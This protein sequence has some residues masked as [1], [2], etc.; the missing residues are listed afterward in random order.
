MAYRRAHRVCRD[1][2]RGTCTPAACGNF[3][4]SSLSSLT[5]GPIHYYSATAPV[6]A[7]PVPRHC[8]PSVSAGQAGPAKL[9]FSGVLTKSICTNIPRLRAITTI[10]ARA[11]AASVRREKHHARYHVEQT[12]L[13]GHSPEGVLDRLRACKSS[14]AGSLTA[15]AWPR[16]PLLA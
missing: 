12:R 4:S 9:T 13:H 15:A 2:K 1:C 6:H 7:F 8:S 5:L 3:D 16:N 11:S 10:R 14:P